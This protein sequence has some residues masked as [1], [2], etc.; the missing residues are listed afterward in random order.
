[1]SGTTDPRVTEEQ[2]LRMEALQII[3]WK[4]EVE[5]YDP[6]YWNDNSSYVGRTPVFPLSG[7]MPKEHN[8]FSHIRKLSTCKSM[9]WSSNER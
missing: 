2:R 8:S 9:A 4:K 6:D 5:Q 1:M 7:S 3:K